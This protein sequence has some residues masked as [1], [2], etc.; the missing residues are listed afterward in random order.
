MGPRRLADLHASTA[1]IAAAERIARAL[2]VGFQLCA[3]EHH[4]LNEIQQIELVKAALLVFDDFRGD[5][6]SQIRIGTALGSFGVNEG[7]ASPN[8]ADRR[9]DAA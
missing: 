6:E 7:S 8:G 5:V 4:P 1:Q 3:D 9:R 2:I